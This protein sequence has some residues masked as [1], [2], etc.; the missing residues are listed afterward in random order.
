MPLDQIVI[1]S[2]GSLS[3]A[4]LALLMVVLQLIL[5]MRKPHFLLY[6][7]S[8]AI[9]FSAFI[10]AIGIF[11][12]YN[13]PPGPISLMAGKL[14]WTA[15][16]F[17]VH[18]LFGFT[19]V[20]MGMDG[21]RYHAIAAMIHCFLLTLLWFTDRLVSDQF[22]TRHFAGMARPF[23]EP[24]LGPWGHLFIVYATL[25]S[26]GTIAFWIRHN[27]LNRRYHRPYLIGFV[28][29]IGLGIHD[30]L[31]A[32]G[33]V[34]SQYLMEY[35]FLVFSMIVLWVV[36]SK[37]DEA[38]SEGKY[39]MIT[40]LANDGILVIQND[41][42]IFSNPACSTLLDRSVD[43]MATD[44]FL[45]FLTPADRE[46]LTAYYDGLTDGKRIPDTLTLQ[47][48]RTNGTEKVVEFKASVVQYNHQPAVLAV[49]RDITERIRE[50]KAL[51]QSEEKVARLK[52]MES[53]GLLAGGVAHDL[54]N[55]LS[56]IVSY[57][58]LLLMELPG[59]SPLRQ[60][61]HT[62]KKS[63]LRA[64]AIVQDLLTIARGVA[65]EK[66]PLSL[67]TAVQNFMLSAEYQNLQKFHPDV[68]FNIKMDRQLLNINGSPIHIDKVVMNLASN[69]AEAIEGSGEVIVSTMNRYVD[70]PLKK[71]EDVKPGEYAV[72]CVKDNG[73]GIS[74]DDMKRIFEP[75]YTKK[76]MG[77]S[78]T[79]LG[80]SVVWNVMQDH[81]GYIDITSDSNGTSFEL[82][83]PITRETVIDLNDT[84][85]IE[86]I[87]GDGEE[88]LVVDD[89]KSQREITSRMLKKWGYTT[90]TVASGEAAIEFVKNQ[91]VALI[92]LDMI[93]DPGMD[94]LETY[95]R[96]KA[97][98]P[99]Q[100]AILLS[101]FAQTD[102]VKEALSLGAGRFMKK[103][104]LF[105]ALAKAVKEELTSSNCHLP[106]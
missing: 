87:C 24:A 39:R 19:F 3:V 71:Y 75:F 89:V 69:A 44:D 65:V 98:R 36:F 1:Q 61:V 104:V 78:G 42:V 6:A 66:Q 59:E 38:A 34:T 9:S 86:T 8:A 4:V 33:I 93:M 88:I 83:F 26:I 74:P 27:G 49:V 103:P 43:D 11:I 47:L 67:N 2:A 84:I 80:L 18:C 15:I 85:D 37:N 13:F 52:K 100:K 64:A 55:V 25:A 81:E 28:F 68:S 22:A 73:P 56:G 90:H 16:V 45:N 95:R 10:Y 60:P 41:H 82:Y 32:L 46:P 7:W 21:R 51:R 70:Q 5:L 97:S 29:W 99:D 40:E 77:R 72:L 102:Q 91:P 23:V 17:Q 35:G 12:E 92:L 94:G 79:G 106:N 50:E 30:G 58:D 57:P 62:M 20:T 105:G 96:I 53:L 54:N 76:V 48:N 101:G 14:E 63:G 31:A